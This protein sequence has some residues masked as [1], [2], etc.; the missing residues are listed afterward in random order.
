M[1]TS[2]HMD[3]SERL[4]LVLSMPYSDSSSALPRNRQRPQWENVRSDEGWRF[5]R[6]LRTS[7]WSCGWSL[8]TWARIISSGSISLLDLFFSFTKLVTKPWTGDLG[9]SKHHFRQGQDAAP[10]VFGSSAQRYQFSQPCLIESTASFWLVLWYKWLFPHLVC[11]CWALRLSGDWLLPTIYKNSAWKKNRNEKERRKHNWRA[12]PIRSSLKTLAS[13]TCTLV[14][15]TYFW[16][17]AKFILFQWNIWNISM[18]IKNKD[19]HGQAAPASMR[20]RHVPT[21]KDRPWST[22]QLITSG[23]EQTIEGLGTKE[24]HGFE[25]FSIY[26]PWWAYKAFMDIQP[27]VCQRTGGQLSLQCPSWVNSKIS[28][29]T[30]SCR[31]YGPCGCQLPIP[32]WLPTW[33]PML[34]FD[35]AFLFSTV[36]KNESGHCTTQIRCPGWV[37]AW[38][39]LRRALL[40]KKM[41]PHKESQ[42]QHSKT[43]AID[44]IEDPW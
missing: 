14:T 27:W 10:W 16:C 21:I 9:Q 17:M 8:Q 2:H 1:F 44:A 29:K 15:K 31:K 22:W 37:S 43:T 32:G 30:K 41:Q 12:P 13:H 34:L 28:R 3:I 42:E 5:Q 20:W 11:S 33:W 23:K 38:S 25:I 18:N 7:H 24:F 36:F 4:T 40:C 6:D 35:K 19:F 39:I 26:L